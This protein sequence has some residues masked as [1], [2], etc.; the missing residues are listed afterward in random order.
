MGVEVPHIPDNRSV[1][2][3]SGYPVFGNITRL[4]FVKIKVGAVGDS[5]NLFIEQI[6]EGLCV[7]AS[8][9]K[10]LSNANISLDCPHVR[11]ERGGGGTVRR[12]APLRST[13]ELYAS[14]FLR[15]HTYEE[16]RRHAHHLHRGELRVSSVRA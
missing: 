1:M 6:A 12:E 5:T 16:S 10:L 11:A 4:T 7:P 15:G 14:I 2:R 8:S 3:S 13:E 9:H